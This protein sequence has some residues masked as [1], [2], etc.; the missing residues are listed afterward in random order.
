M[1]VIIR[2]QGLPWS[3]SALDI[4]HFFKGLTIPA[5]GVHII[6]GE[7]GDAFIAFGSDEDARQAMMRT[8]LPL[9]GT[10]VQLFLSS[11][12]EMQNVIEEARVA[13]AAVAMTGSAVT[14]LGGSASLQGAA[15]GQIFQGPNYP[16]P[17]GAASQRFPLQGEL[18]AARDGQGQIPSGPP[19]GNFPGSS[20]SLGLQNRE[21]PTQQQFGFQSDRSQ[22]SSQ[23]SY[24]GSGSSQI[25]SGSNQFRMSEGNQ[26][27]DARYP[28]NQDMGNVDFSGAQEADYPVNDQ[29]QWQGHGQDMSGS[30]QYF[31]SETGQGKFGFQGV[32]SMQRSE[33]YPSHGRDG[34]LSGHQQFSMQGGDQTHSQDSL[35]NQQN[36]YAPEVKQQNDSRFTMRQ[37]KSGFSEPLMAGVLQRPGLPVADDEQTGTRGPEMKGVGLLGARPGATPNVRGLGDDRVMMQGPMRSNLP[38]DQRQGKGFEHGRPGASLEEGMPGSVG[39]PQGFQRGQGMLPTPAMP[40]LSQQLSHTDEAYDEV[41]A[42]ERGHWPGYDE[43]DDMNRRG[44]HGNFDERGDHTMDMRQNA[45]LSHPDEERGRGQFIDGG[46]SDFRSG[47]RPGGITYGGPGNRGGGRRF[48]GRG[49][50]FDS[51]PGSRGVNENDRFSGPD[52][53]GFEGPREHQGMREFDHQRELGM[54]DVGVQEMEI[55]ESFPGPRGRGF[56]GARGRGSEGARGRGYDRSRGRGFDRPDRFGPPGGRDFSRQGYAEEQEQYDP[57]AM[58]ME[59]EENQYGGAPSDIGRGHERGFDEER[60]DMRRPP[61]GNRDF[62]SRG[63][64]GRGRGDGRGRGGGPGSGFG[65]EMD[66]DRRWNKEDVDTRGRERNWRDNTEVRATKGLLGDAPAGLGDGRPGM[67]HAFEPSSLKTDADKDQRG[68]H[69]RDA[70]RERE[71]RGYADR[72]YREER[73]RDDSRNRG[74]DDRFSKRSDRRS[75]ERGRGRDE[76]EKSFDRERSSDRHSR[77]SERD[78]RSDRRDREKDKD[79]DRERSSTKDRDTKSQQP[80]SKTLDSGSKD[81]PTEKKPEN[82]KNEG[83]KNSESEKK[84]DSEVRSTD[85]PQTSDQ[86]FVHVKNIPQTFNYK[87]IRRLF[88]GCEIPFDGLKIINDISGKRIGEAF[89]KFA[90]EESGKKALKKNGERILGNTIAISVVSSKE[91]ESKIDSQKPPE[92]PDENPSKQNQ[93]EEPPTV[94]PQDKSSLIVLV[95]GLPPNVSR[96]ELA[97]FFQTVKIADNG[98]AI[99]IEYDSRGQCTGLAYMEVSSVQDFKVAMGYDGRLFGARNLKISV[100]R[101]EEM[102]VLI[103]KQQ[104][105]FQRQSHKSGEQ[106]GPGLLGSAPSSRPPLMGARPAPMPLMSLFQGPPRNGPVLD[107]HQSKVPYGEKSHYGSMN[108]PCVHLQGLSMMVTYKEI[109]EFFQGLNIVPRGVQIVHD[110]MGKPMGEGFVEFATPEDRDEALKKDKTSMGHRVVAVKSISKSDMIERLRNARLV[111]LPPGQGP[112]PMHHFKHGGGPPLGPKPIPPGVLNPQWYYLRCQNFPGNTTIK[113]ILNFFHEFQPIPESIR[114]HF[115]ADGSQTG[116]ALVGFGAYEDRQRALQDMNG[117]FFRRSSI[118]LQPVSG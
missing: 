108:S 88:V 29:Q 67:L 49:G 16:G 68:P 24:S 25:P 34:Q 12:S 72:R 31:G 47:A 30:R 60:Q 3:A 37:G 62:D 113:D 76:R 75:Y 13:E 4:R 87:D 91:F 40:P 93:A 73:G 63:E 70:E 6:G 115:S 92:N 83:G 104:D 44:S 116:N 18:H 58:Q 39:M 65:R 74:R 86:R 77:R 7:R 117:K 48:G 61:F 20:H 114:L 57:Y 53:R 100:G 66:T 64:R 59:G 1:S 8:L 26:P 51:F 46:D 79:R 15:T 11:K 99:F 109:R 84:S 42:M 5:G 103:K 118:N 32:Q 45:D 110:G 112:P 38:M 81:S 95:Q 85:S 21:I 82:E 107:Q 106:S 33:Q 102:D 97:S 28:Y 78:H 2:L 23:I 56:E 17:H 90:N 35:I 111:G 36:F 94:K 27:S 71:R 19:S 43:G 89:I 69:P 9:S 98:D 55:D 14:P 101:R 22:A 54:E 80:S 52:G 10:P 50:R 96:E 41:T 105:M